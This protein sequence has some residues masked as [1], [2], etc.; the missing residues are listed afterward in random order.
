M[1]TGVYKRTKYHIEIMRV[2]HT[3]IGKPVGERLLKHIT[4]K[5]NC[6]LTN[7]TKDR[8]GYARIGCRKNNKYQTSLA[9]RVSFEYFSK[10]KIPSDKCVLHRCDNPSCVNPTHLYLGTKTDNGVD[11]RE[12]NRVKG[13]KNGYAKLT[14]KDVY[15]IR[16]LKENGWSYQKL[17]RKYG[18]VFSAIAHIIKGRRWAHLN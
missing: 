16:L 18:V 14:E 15:K 7:L 10:V 12:R 17:A 11:M 8:R 1:P 6:W 2:S 9:H 13:S 3:G 5:K 4:S